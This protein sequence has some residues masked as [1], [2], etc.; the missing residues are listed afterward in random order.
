MHAR[1]GRLGW[2]G[3]DRGTR[4]WLARE[5]LPDR[6][7]GHPG[8]DAELVDH[9]NGIEQGARLVVEVVADVE[10][11]RGD[12]MLDWPRQQPRACEAEHRVALVRVGPARHHARAGGATFDRLE[13][14]QLETVRL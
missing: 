8:L 5:Q 3:A 10:P 14:E 11:E 13:L 2:R 12:L 7:G 1:S 6:V 9:R 4:S